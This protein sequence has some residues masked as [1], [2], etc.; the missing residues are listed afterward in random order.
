M[1]QGSPVDRGGLFDLTGLVAVVVGISSTLGLAMAQGLARYGARIAGIGRTPEKTDAARTALTEGGADCATFL[2][3]ATRRDELLRARDAVLNW[4][5]RVD[6]LLNAVG[7]TSATPFL[8]VTDEEWQRI[9]DTNLKSVWLGCQVFGETMV[10]QRS[11]SIIN[12]SSVSADRP[13]SR[14]STYSLTKAGV[15]SLTK[16]LAREWG[17]YGVR[18]NAIVPGFFPS[19]LNRRLLDDERMRGILTHTPLG[20]LG[21]AEELQGAAVWLAAPRAAS[22]VTGAIVRVDGG[23]CVTAI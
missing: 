8:Q 9:L 13:L 4:A 6:V 19:A 18:V 7:T 23:F 20:R 11:G 2:A 15:E 12:I 21:E 1:D 14:V 22:F 10:A 16:F 17:P 5:G 3:D